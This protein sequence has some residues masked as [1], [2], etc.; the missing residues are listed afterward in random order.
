MFQTNKSAAF[1]IT[2]TINHF[3]KYSL[4]MT[5]AGDKSEYKIWE[6]NAD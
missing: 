5:S 2:F 6:C 4:S 3:Y 1:A